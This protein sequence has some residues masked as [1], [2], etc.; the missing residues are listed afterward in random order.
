[1][2]T[3]TMLGNMKAAELLLHYGQG[4]PTDH[5]EITGKDGAPLTMRI[6][7]DD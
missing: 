1:M 3:Q 2:K 4:K 5:V 6:I 7:I